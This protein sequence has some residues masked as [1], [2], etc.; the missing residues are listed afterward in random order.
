MFEVDIEEFMKKL[1]LE[2]I[3]KSHAKMLKVKKYLHWIGFGRWWSYRWSMK[4][5]ESLPFLKEGARPSRNSYAKKELDQLFWTYGE[6][7]MSVL[8]PYNGKIC[9]TMQHFYE[10]VTDKLAEYQH[11]DDCMG[12]LVDFLGVDLDV[13][14]KNRQFGQSRRERH[15]VEVLAEIGRKL[16]ADPNWKVAPE[17]INVNS[18]YGNLMLEFNTSDMGYS[19][20]RNHLQFLLMSHN[21]NIND[22]RV[23]VF[24]NRRCRESYK[25]YD[26]Y[27]NLIDRPKNFDYEN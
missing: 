23:F 26:L 10:N 3:H 6:D 17:S 25:V 27:F 8:H 13:F 7:A 4:V 5:V 15:V 9:N 2:D 1:T 12:I 19:Y 14:S 18:S 11:T 24:D 20:A 22:I 21:F 16:K